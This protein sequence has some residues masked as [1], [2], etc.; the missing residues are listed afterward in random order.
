M[1]TNYQPTG[2]M[3]DALPNVD[4]LLARRDKLIAELKP[5][6]ARYGGQ[7]N[8]MGERLFKIEEAKIE[9]VVRTRAKAAGVKLTEAAVEAEVRTHEEYEPL[10]VKELQSRE[11][12]IELEEQLQTLEWRLH[13]RK[14]D[15]FLLGGEARLAT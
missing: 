5:L 7:G 8:Y 4:V 15:A 13:M 10:L 14:T 3:L 11:R 9:L 6:R 2:T 12:W 1:G